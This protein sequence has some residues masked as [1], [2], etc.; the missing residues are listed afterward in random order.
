MGWVRLA[1]ADIV[2]RE[3]RHRECDVN[4]LAARADL[5]RTVLS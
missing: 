4:I 5:A 3:A 1:S 2:G